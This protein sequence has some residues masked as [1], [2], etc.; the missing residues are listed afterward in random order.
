MGEKIVRLPG[1][2]LK[3]GFDYFPLNCDFFENDKIKALRRA[4]GEVGVLTYLNILCRIYRTHGYYYECRDL[5]ALAQDIAEQIANDRIRRKIACVRETINYLI[6]HE[7]LD[8]GLAERG[9]ISGIAMQ[10]KYIEMVCR[11]RRKINMD[12]HVLVDVR[13]V[14]SKIRDNAEEIPIIAE[15]DTVNTEEMQQSK[16]KSK[17]KDIFSLS[18]AHA[19]GKHQNVILTDKQ[20]RELEERGVPPDYIDHFS[21]KLHDRHYTYPDHFSAILDWWKDDKKG[22]TA[23]RAKKE[24][25]LGEGAAPSNFDTDEFFDAAV[26]RSYG[27]KYE[28]LFGKDMDGNEQGKTD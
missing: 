25:P 3:E 10:E 6:S 13:L 23:K 21:E 24:A 2:P 12:V 27:D 28:E 9:I 19:R 1:R 17:D 5:D 8:R 16:E 18:N 22:W 15:E 4:L 11:A 14:I 20:V 26:K 7:I